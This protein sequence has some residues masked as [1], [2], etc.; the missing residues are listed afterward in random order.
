MQK[1]KHFVKDVGKMIIVFFLIIY[2]LNHI[3]YDMHQD[4]PNSDTC[5][6]NS[7]NHGANIERPSILQKLGMGMSPILEPM[8]VKSDNWQA[9]VTILTGII[10]KELVIS[11]VNAL[12][13]DENFTDGFYGK[14][15]VFC[16]LLFILLYFPCISVFSTIAKTL[17]FRWAMFSAIWSSSLAY[18]SATLCY[19]ALNALYY[20]N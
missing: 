14:I 16:Y 20:S 11:S 6:T 7:I 3:P 1:T 8:G 13:K 19:Q 2:S 12:Y 5:Q 18:A 17:G 4:M 10:G 15:G 9:S